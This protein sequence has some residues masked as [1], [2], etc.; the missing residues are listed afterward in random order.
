MV[1]SL[2]A[3]IGNWWPLFA[4]GVAVLGVGR[5]VRVATYDK[6]PPAMWWRQTWT[7]WVVKHNHQAWNDLMYCP[8]CL[9][10]W[11]ALVCIGWFMLSFTVVWIA[12]TWWLF[13]GWGAIAY[14]ISMVIVR[15]E[16]AS[17]D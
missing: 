13:W 4:L 16:P 9:T 8:W 6:F 17:N 3:A 5:W 2:I 1:E 10:P 14:L 11:V 15:D 12:W 7:N